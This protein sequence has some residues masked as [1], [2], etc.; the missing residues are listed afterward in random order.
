MRMRFVSAEL[1]AAFF[2]RRRREG[3]GGAELPAVRSDLPSV[4]LSAAV[5]C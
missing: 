1:T 5:P 3:E 4:Q 2:S